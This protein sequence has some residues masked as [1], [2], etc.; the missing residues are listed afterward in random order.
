MFDPRIWLALW[1]LPWG[2]AL[3]AS[4]IRLAARSDV[5]LGSAQ[6][7]TAFRKDGLSQGTHDRQNREATVIE[8]H[9]SLLAVT[10]LLHDRNRE[11]AMMCKPE[12]RRH[13]R[14]LAEAHQYLASRGFLVLPH[15]WANGRW[16]AQTDS[17]GEGVVVSI[18]LEVHEVRQAG[19]SALWLRRGNRQQPFGGGAQ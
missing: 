16:Q 10:K 6:E 2:F 12:I 19:S 7:T 15:G 8:D 13:C 18:S 5:S 17:D 4:S 3:F 11:T 1:T 14:T 9:R